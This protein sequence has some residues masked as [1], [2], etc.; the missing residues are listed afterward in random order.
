MTKV[1]LASFNADPSVDLW[2]SA[3]ARR[4][5]QKERKGYKPRSSDR[6]L[7]SRA[8]EDHSEESEPDSDMLGRWDEMMNSGSDSDYIFWLYLIIIT[9][10]CCHHYSPSNFCADFTITCS[11]I[12]VI[13]MK[14]AITL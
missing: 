5:S 1:P 3:K 8:E 2:W 13:Y 4:P 10:Y 12:L 11:D 9:C 6:P 14:I 7:T